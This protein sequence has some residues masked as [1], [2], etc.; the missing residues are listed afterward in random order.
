MHSAGWKGR[1]R[2]AVRLT[3]GLV[4]VAACLTSLG[5]LTKPV[6]RAYADGPAPCDTGGP[7]SP[8]H[9]YCATYGGRNTFYGSYG[10]GFPT[11]TGWGFCAEN[12][13]TGGDYPSPSFGYAP[14]GAP[15]GADTANDNALGFALSQAQAAGW[16]TN[17]EGPSSADDFAAA[18][19]ILYDNVVWGQGIPSMPYGTLNAFSE[20][21]SWYNQAAGA[22]GSPTI[23]IG[24]AGGGTT[25][26]GSA[27]VQLHVQFPGSGSPTQGLGILM[28]VS[29]ATFNNASGPAAVGVS[30]DSG[31]NVTIPIFASVGGPVTVSAATAVGQVGIGFY[32]S[33]NSA[34]QDLAAFPAPTTLSEDLGLTNNGASINQQGT[35]SIQKQVDDGAY[36]G[37]SGAVFDIENGSGIVEALTTGADGTTPYSEPLIAGDYTVHESLAPPGYS[38][39]PDQAVTV[40]SNQNTVVSYSGSFEEHVQPAEISI[41]KGTEGAESTPVAGAVFDVRY[42]QFNSGTFGDDLG[43]C[44]TDASGSCLP[45]SND[46]PG[47]SFLPGYYQVTEVQAPP[48]YY[49][50]PPTTI[51]KYAGAASGA[52]FFFADFV[53][54]SVQIDK[55][56]DDSSYASVNGAVFSLVGPLPSTDQAGTLTIGSNGQSNIVDNLTSGS[57][58]LTEITPPTGYQPIATQTI[59]LPPE[60]GNAPAPVT[61]INVLDHIQPAS[62]IIQKIDQATNAPLAGAVFDVRYDP[63]GSGT[64]STDL[65]QC[66]TSVGGTCAPAG[67]D[68]PGQ[69][70]P[71]NYQ[72]TEIGAPPGYQLVPGSATQDLKLTPGGTGQAIFKD[73]LLVPAAFHKVAIGNIN[74]TQIS[75]AGAVI[76]ILEGSSSGPDV[77][78]CTTDASGTCTTSAVLVSGQPYCWV[79]TTAP[80]GLAAGANGCFT[81]DNGHGAQPITITDPGVFTGIAVKKVDE[82]NSTAVL[83]DAVID[84]YRVDQGD[85]PGNVA[86]PPGDAATEAGETW[87]AR[88]TTDSTGMAAFPLQY[89][90]YAY[91]AVENAAPANYRLTP[92]QICSPVLKGATTAP[93]TVSIITMA[94]SEAMVALSAH[95][96]NSLMP[97]TV[98][99]GATYDLYVQGNAPPG[100]VPTPSPTPAPAPEL[101]D[102]WYDRG[103]T[104]AAG[105]LTFTVPAGFAWCLLEVSA[106]VNYSLDPALH[107][108][109]VLNANA[110][111]SETTIAL[112]ETLTTVY[113][114]AHKFNSLNPSSS[115]PGATYELLLQGE[116]P[117][118]PPVDPAPSNIQV[119]TGDTYWTQGTSDSQGQLSFGVPAGYSWC[120]HELAPSPTSY[121]LDP[122]FHCTAVLNSSTA[123]AAMTIALAETPVPESPPAVPIPLLA[124]TGAPSMWLV[125]GGFL[126]VALGCALLRISHRARWKRSRP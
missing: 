102:T 54:D 1:V 110:P 109:A 23:T 63:N 122:G 11:A 61:V 124:F 46:G 65:G 84:L 103:T 12:A 101:G 89:P 119:P 41:F 15:L 60:T 56:G 8:F 34:A 106:P 35:L 111:A 123:P 117:P 45:P 104:D 67:N 114:S 9:G 4:A 77:A 99:P 14:S 96:F 90:G 37:P 25:F 125:W 2:A 24:I 20:L 31:G 33:A 66:T 36:Y 79:E 50:S 16:W 81:A 19:K 86:T 3:A 85:G 27:F 58:T 49:A 76:Q 26:N 94:D 69:F 97:A 42:D 107:C 113:V 52:S 126:F 93:P 80:P 75:Y 10:L 83:P 92:G 62:A 118:N 59:S 73:P 121:Q 47:D 5:V 78:S 48:G 21:D 68:G 74:P 120:L 100:G 108:T 98:I 30:T 18:G 116:P 28:T 72:V 39:A 87:V 29:G 7:T 44:T 64:Y 115:I 51:T 57:Y 22:T 112:P 43:T 13:A 6:T 38:V 40:Y 91:C 71:G 17:G 88:A 53:A 55:S 32:H 70:L 95:K 82:A 105:N